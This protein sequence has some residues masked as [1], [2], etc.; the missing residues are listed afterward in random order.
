[1]L[2]KLLAAIGIHGLFANAVAAPVLLAAL[3][4]IWWPLRRLSKVDPA[5]ALR[6][7]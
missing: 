1:M 6:H 5:S 7:E 2:A 4:A 3:A